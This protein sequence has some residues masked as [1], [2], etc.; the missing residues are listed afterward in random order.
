MSS[1]ELH[2]NP[3]SRHPDPASAGEGSKETIV[4]GQH[5]GSFARLRITDRVSRIFEGRAS[6]F[7]LPT[8]RCAPLPH[9]SPAWRDAGG[10]SLVEVI[11][12]VGL[13]AASVTVVIA[14]LPALTR[15]GAVTQDALAAQRLPDALKI[16]LSR[17]ATT[18]GFDA[19]AGQ[20]P[21]MGSPGGGL[22]FVA[23]HDVARLHALNY[24]PPSGALI[25]A[26]EQYFLIECWRFPDEPLRYDAQKHFLALAVRV[27]WPYRFP[28]STAPT[29]GTSRAQV[30]FTVSL[31]R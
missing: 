28:G 27:S 15:H 19:L 7:A 21:V 10:F 14:L 4:S 3:P 1:I 6:G 2:P 30:N 29:D 8:K 24:L 13:F 16:E 26:S 18:G 17:L 31:T 11:I 20:A 22:A 12:A 5:L 25:P 23:T 9:R